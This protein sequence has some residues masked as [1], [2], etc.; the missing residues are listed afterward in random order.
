MASAPPSLPRR[1]SPRGSHRP[2]ALLAASLFAGVILGVPLA[3]HGR[4][5][6]M[7][8]EPTIMVVDLHVD[9]PWQVHFK[10][11][12][13]DQMIPRHGL[14][15]PEA[16]RISV[17]IADALSRAHAAG[18]IHRDLKPANIMVN[19]EGQV[20]VLDFGLA[21][22]TGPIEPGELDPTLTERPH[23]EDGTILGTLSYM[24]PEQTEGKKLDPRSDIFS[25]GAVLYEMLTGRRA[26]QGE[27]KASTMA[28]ILREDPK[29]AREVAAAVPA[30]LERIVSR[31]LR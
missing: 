22:L 31:A 17:Q 30:E 7:D 19:A 1:P 16:L 3:S 15:V 23:T 29:P 21:K 5:A 28:A 18:I 14:A 11:R 9:L 27:S 25:F 4:A 13:L 2:A 8:V 10:G 26:F 6:F 20:K 24:S 12:S